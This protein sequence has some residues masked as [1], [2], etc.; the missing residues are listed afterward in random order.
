MDSRRNLAKLTFATVLLLTLGGCVAAPSPPHI[1][2]RYRNVTQPAIQ[3]GVDIDFYT[4]PGQDIA[5]AARQDVAYAES[6]HANALSVSFPYFTPGPESS[7]VEA[8]DTTPSPRDLAILASVAEQAGLF[9]SLRPLLDEGPHSIATSRT[10]WRPANARAWF[11]SYQKFLLP[12]AAMAQRAQ[13]PE[14]VDGAE[15][16][17]F[18]GSQ[19]WAGL[20]A[21]LRAVYKGTFVY[22][23]NWGIPLAGKGGPGVVESVDSYQPLKVGVDASLARLTAAWLAY[24]RTLPAGTVETEIDIAAVPGAYARPYKTNWNVTRLDP[25]IQSLW[26]SAACDA[27]ASDHL[28]G[29][30]FWAVGF[31][32][33]LNTP[34]GVTDPADWVDGPGAVAIA[35]CFRKLATPT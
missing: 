25:A 35:S 9:V 5:A 22:A 14:F 2:L 15:F 8:T 27:A 28:G 19:L 33:S 30:Y 4:Y 13:V 1:T 34:P 7:L 18:G 24:D 16:T 3:L 6:L 10:A 17:M 29:L 26:F 12:Y 32:Q 20:V 21:A 31:G 23:N 11:A